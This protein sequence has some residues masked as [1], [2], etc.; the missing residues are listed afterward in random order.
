MNTAFVWIMLTVVFL[1]IE[2][3]TVGMVSIWFMAGSLVALVAS[4]IGAP[5]WLQVVIFIVVS[6]A[7]FALLY[8][9]LKR[10]VRK[11]HQATN[12]DM[13]LGETC[14]VRDRIDNIAET[15]S[16]AIAGKVWTARTADGEIVES[17]EL[18]RVDD[19]QGVKL[20]VTPIKNNS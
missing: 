13:V 8:P 1:V 12:A 18:V 17:G 15:G 4:V 14:V 16:V 10:F 20:I 3:I 7:C 2:L 19:I 11:N 9:R 6:C 5:P